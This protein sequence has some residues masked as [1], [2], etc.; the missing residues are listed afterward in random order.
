MADVSGDVTR[1][2]PARSRRG[3]VGLLTAEAISL[4]GTRLSMIAIPWY[5]ISTTGSPFLTGVVAFAE[6]VPYVL[7]KALGGP[8]IDRFGARRIAITADVVSMLT[9]AAIPLLHL[10]SV[11]PLGVFVSLV[12]L[13]GLLRGPAD[14]ATKTLIPT[15][16]ERAH[17]PLERATGLS[18]TLERLATTVGAAGAGAVVAVIGPIPALALNAAA[19]VLA[20]L[21]VWFTVP[22]APG[23]D[24]AAAEG[25]YLS[26]LRNGFTFL[27]GDRLLRSIA[28][29]LASTNL[30]NAAM[31]SVLLPVW[32]HQTG[33]GPAAM[34]VLIGVFAASAI[35][36][37][38]LASA[39]AHKLPRRA[40]Y[41]VGFVIT[42]APR[43]TVLAFDL[44][45]G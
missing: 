32:A 14:A 23:A 27:V 26:Q 31:T 43:F 15:V 42:G 19:F 37:S 10:L 12:A 33:S 20:P 29:M 7:A 30:L 39:F 45:F 8:L 5:V 35:A 44:P 25:G 18:G 34:G 22:A 9:M 13:L 11:L 17:V 16:V 38:L 28:G 24:A 41:L 1:K 2:A 3:L 40:T 6:G 36:T 21:I 4:S